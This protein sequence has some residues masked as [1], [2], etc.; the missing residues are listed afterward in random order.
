MTFLREIEMKKTLL[1]SGILFIF[2]FTNYSQNSWNWQHPLPQGNPLYGMSIIVDEGWAVGPQGTAIHTSDA[3]VTWEK[4]DL[5]TTEN[6]NSV[7]MH[8]ENMIFIVGDNGLILF[9]F[10]NEVNLEVTQQNSNTNEDLRSVTSNINGCQWIS[11]DY[12]TVLRSTDLGETWIDQSVIN[13]NNLYSLHNIEC[14]TA[15]VAGLNGFVMNSTDWGSTWHVKAVPTTVHLLAVSIGTFDYIRVIGNSGTILLTTDNGTS[16]TTESSGTSSHLND[17]MNIGSSEAYAVGTDGV[18]LESSNFGQP[19][20]QRTSGT[21][22]TLYDVEDHFGYNHIWVTGHYGIILKNSGVG[23]DFE[24]HNAGT[25]LW[26][27]SVEF[28][29]ENTGWAVGG[30][31][32]WSGTNKGRFLR[33]TDGG[34]TWMEDNALTPLNAVDFIS[35]IEG[36]A[37]GEDGTIRHTLSGGSGWGTQTSP[38]SSDL[39]AVCFID[40]DYGWAVGDYGEIIHTTNGGLDWNVQNSSTSNWLYGVCFINA[41]TGWAAGEFATVVHTTDGGQNWVEQ[42]LNPSQNYNLTSVQFL[43]DNYGW[44]SAIYGR[45]FF[46]TNGGST[47][48]EINTGIFESLNEIYFIDINNGWVV[49]DAGTV[50]RSRNGGNTWITQFSDVATNSLSSVCFIDTLN[51]WVSGE[52]GTIIHTSDGGGIVSVETEGNEFTKADKYILSQNFP[53]PFN[54]KTTIK[55]IMPETG[56]V[57]LRIYDVLGREVMILVNQELNAGNQETVFD[58]TNFSSGIY[59]YQLKVGDFIQTKKIVLMK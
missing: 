18:I 42:D 40:E 21:N 47:W 54:P 11:G 53:N 19:W 50:L 10:Y 36:W 28:L 37:V 15:W 38:V 7:F 44:V 13:S 9:V 2:Q 29:D 52:G 45:L 22:A 26:I 34:I 32:G 1:F 16:W 25:R 59:F 57:T 12:G 24:L 8:D 4:I 6:L 49:G 46:T 55:W 20:E 5:G 14:T 41:T 31:A 43:D 30:D 56:F 17:I 39:N 51:G 23:T 33:T 58:A 35:A 27:N 3:G 48:Q